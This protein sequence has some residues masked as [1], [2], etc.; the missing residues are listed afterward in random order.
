MTDIP[1][2]EMLTGGLLAAIG[3]HLKGQP[4]I[5][6]VFLKSLLVAQQQQNMSVPEGCPPGVDGPAAD[7][8][9]NIEGDIEQL[10]IKDGNKPFPR[11]TTAWQSILQE[12]V[13]QYS[14]FSSA[15]VNEIIDHSHLRGKLSVPAGDISKWLKFSPIPSPRNFFRPQQVELLLN[16][17]ADILD[18]CL[19]DRLEWEDKQIKWASLAI[20]IVDFLQRDEIHN[21]EIEA[22]LYTTACTEAAFER[23]G[24]LFD[25]K[26]I[27]ESNSYLCSL[28]NT[29]LSNTIGTGYSLDQALLAFMGVW[30][31]ND[32]SFR[33]GQDTKTAGAYAQ[34]AATGIANF[35]F[36]NQKLPL[37]ASY[38]RNDY[39]KVASAYREL[40]AAER[41]RWLMREVDFQRQRTEQARYLMD[42]RVRL[43]VEKGGPFNYREKMDV[44]SDR[45]NRG[46]NEAV[47]RL[48]AIEIGLD[49]IF[50]FKHPLPQS[51]NEFMPGSSG[52]LPVA[53][54]GI[55][56]D[57][58]E[59]VRQAI[60]WIVR[61]SNFDQSCV[62]TLSLKQHTNQ[63]WED[64]VRYGAWKFK[65]TDEQTGD[66]FG[67]SCIR[68]N[69]V[70]ASVVGG[71]LQGLWKISVK[72][73]RSAVYTHL[74]GDKVSVDQKEIPTLILGRVGT[75]Q[76]LREPDFAARSA[77][78]NF[79][80]LGDWEVTLGDR[81]SRGES[82]LEIEDIELDVEITYQDTTQAESGVIRS[83]LFR[84]G[85]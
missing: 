8:L 13:A 46:F 23:Q 30:S 3:A 24:R 51:V 50:G 19:R 32:K 20:E 59:W 36:F 75:R 31:F 11:D 74:G 76:L 77:F 80:P 56:D 64:G 53:S 68:I 85:H 54:S 72:P 25:N 40:A 66:F 65:L 12:F 18:R 70:S 22:G 48:K 6:S 47:A 45:I 43:A 63:A 38:V 52:V 78:R 41:Q 67:M 27:A 61:F 5:D 16:Q 15:T 84:S 55:L 42:L 1:R 2:R 44:V 14:L 82:R 33:W 49:T 83:T 17:A 26:A 79:S 69:S 7:L 58:V 28:L 39:E 71:N 4:V 60:A 29:T 21:G 62:V 9:R 10:D 34:Q 35:N 37:L 57:C 81:S 73:P